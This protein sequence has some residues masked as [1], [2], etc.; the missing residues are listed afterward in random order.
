MSNEYIVSL[1]IWCLL[2]VSFWL[3]VNPSAPMNNGRTV[4][5]GFIAEK[6]EKIIFPFRW[7]KDRPTIEYIFGLVLLGNIISIV[8]LKIL[9]NFDKVSDR[10][11]E[12][13]HNLTRC[14]VLCLFLAICIHFCFTIKTNMVKKIIYYFLGVIFIILFISTIVY[15][16]IV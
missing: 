2:Y 14:V 8:C 16:F 1:L 5:A 7:Y 4:R 11:F 9:S 10:L 3:N 12:F 6:I 13:T 15:P